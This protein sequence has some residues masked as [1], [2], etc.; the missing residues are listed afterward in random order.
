MPATLCQPLVSQAGMEVLSLVSG[1]TSKERTA[2]YMLILQ[3]CIDDS[4]THKGGKIFALSGFI[5]SAPEWIEFA[6]EWKATLDAYPRIEYFKMREAARLQDQFTLF[7]PGARDRK[8][9]D[10]IAVRSEEHTSELQAR[11]Y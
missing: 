5:A 11:Q 1:F 4:G 2:R 8:L 3:P 7:T 9:R 6:D 10:L